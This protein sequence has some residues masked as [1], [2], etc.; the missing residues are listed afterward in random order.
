MSHKKCPVCGTEMKSIEILKNKLNTA[1]VVEDWSI[2]V[3]RADL[4]I[5]K[6]PVCEHGA[7]DNFLD[8]EFYTDFSVA[9]G[10]DIDNV[11][12]IN[13]RSKQFG[14]MIQ[15][16]SDNAPDTESLLEIGSGC[17]YLLNAAKNKFTK[18]LGVEPSKVEYEISKQVASGCEVIN[19]F[20]SSA[21]N[22]K[23]RFSAFIAT[24]VFEHIPD[25]GDAIRYAYDVLKDD[26]IGFITVPNG[27]RAFRGGVTMIYI[28]SICTIFH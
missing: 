14:P 4:D 24:M 7:I 16:M 12:A 10:G 20:F 6:C 8:K 11:A 25:I 15:F 17:G 2:K 3:N 26:G 18:I 22:I 19:D 27:Q 23:N 5:Y 13:Q 28:P 9:L 1:N 21:L